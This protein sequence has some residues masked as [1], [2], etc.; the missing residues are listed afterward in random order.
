MS[1]QLQTYWRQ[2]ACGGSQSPLARLLKL[3]LIPP[4]LIYAAVTYL[5]ALAY[6][7]GIFN[8]KRLP[9]PVISVG[10]LTVGGT[11]K[12]PVTI[13]IARFLISKGIRPAV[14]SRGYGGSLEGKTAIVSDGRQLQLTPAECGDEPF[15]LASSV[16]GLMVVIGADRH[17]A[18]Q[19]AMQALQ[20]DIFILDDAFQH[21]KL[22][23]D[24]NILL[25]DYQRPL[26]N[27]W[28][29]PA[30]LLREPSGAQS[31]ADL[32]IRTRAPEHGE[33]DIPTAAGK[34][35]LTA[36]HRLSGLVPLSGG[37][38]LEFDR[39][40]GRK[41]LAF[42]GIAEPE[43]FFQAL[44]EQGLQIVARIPF[45]DHATYDEKQTDQLTAAFAASGA[46]LAVTTEKD[47]VKLAHL[48]DALKVQVLQARLGLSFSP[49]TPLEEQLLKLL[50]KPA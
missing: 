43:P 33:A 48:P 7:C 27:G 38:L 40:K 46:E 6:R 9:R 5:R 11:G 35:V 24:L 49:A 39:F 4:A 36:S 41:V 47:G 29:L 37:P 23:R 18:G 3:L 20:P 21:L 15:L 28:S 17:A 31:R 16:P 14:L 30:G 13:H 8:V 50:Q 26:G 34:A 42:A 2:M 22:H 32:L 25:M 1:A 12:T 45:A 19:L 10:N 44:A